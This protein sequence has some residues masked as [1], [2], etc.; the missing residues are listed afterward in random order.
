MRNSRK[1]S[2]PLTRVSF[3]ALEENKHEVEM[4]K[5]KW[6]KIVDSVEIQRETSIEIYDKLKNLEKKGLHKIIKKQNIIVINLGEIW[7]FIQMEQ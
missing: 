5:N 4:F 6:K 1:Q 3:V 2:L 7:Q